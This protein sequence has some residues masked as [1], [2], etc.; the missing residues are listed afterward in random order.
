[1][2]SDFAFGT[3][4]FT[5]HPHNTT[6]RARH[7]NR[8][9]SSTAPVPT[10]PLVFLLIVKRNHIELTRRFPSLIFAILASKVSISRYRSQ[11]SLRP[12]LRMSACRLLSEWT[13][14]KVGML[15]KHLLCA[16]SFASADVVP[17]YHINPVS[18][19]R[20]VTL[21]SRWNQITLNKVPF[22]KQTSKRSKQALQ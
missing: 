5:L 13:I 14:H 15:W 8:C 19:L 9:Y 16:V 21:I 12:A 18:P 6:Q 20:H 3:S 11:P 10:H 2:N 7:R 22:A 4:K 1:M 17:L